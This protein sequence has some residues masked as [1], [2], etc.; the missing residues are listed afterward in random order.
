MAACGLSAGCHGSGSRWPS[1]RL[2]AGYSTSARTLGE[3]E[4]LAMGK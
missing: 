2:R 1:R 4:L 3:E